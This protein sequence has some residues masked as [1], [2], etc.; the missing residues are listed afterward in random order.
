MKRL[1]TFIGSFGLMHEIM[2]NK[3]FVESLLKKHGFVIIE[4]ESVPSY[5]YRRGD[6]SLHVF[7]RKIK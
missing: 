2:F 4:G 7:S 5:E 3:K 1:L 6:D